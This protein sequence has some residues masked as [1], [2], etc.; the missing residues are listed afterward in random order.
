MN[1]QEVSRHKQN[2]ELMVLDALRQFTI[3]TKR[4]I[5]SIDFDFE[6]E[7]DGTQKTF[8]RVTLH[9]EGAGNESQ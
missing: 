3:T 8:S 2:A 6:P 1:K 5:R 7:T 9:L 4:H